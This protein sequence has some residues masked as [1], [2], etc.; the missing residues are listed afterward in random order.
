MT[1]AVIIDCLRTAVG[2]APRG[3][4][5]NTRP[6][7]MAAAVFKKLLEKHPQVNKAEID[8]VIL[9]CAMPEAES[10]MNFARIAAL[11]AGLPETVPGVTVNRFCSSGLQA[12]AMAAEKIRSGSAEIVLAGGAE[13]MSL[14]P[15][16]GNKFAPNP[17]MVDHI[18]EIYMGM[19]LTA[20]EVYRKYGISREEQDQFAYRSHRNALQA[21][22]KGKF[23]DEIVP[24]ELDTTALSNG[25]PSTEKSVF[26]KDEGP[27]ADTSPEALAKLK[28]VFHANGTVTAGNSSQTSDGAA[29][30][31]VMSEKKARELG[32]KPMARFVSF[33][34]G[35]VPPE[36][37]GIGPVVAIPKAL[38]LAGLKLGDIGVVELNEAFAVQSLAVIREAGL[39]MDTLNVNG[40]AI[41]LGHPLGC[42]GAKL[43]AT[44]L[45]EMARR[46]ARYGMVTMCIG[47]G[48]GAAGILER[49]N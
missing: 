11:R 1:E 2:K 40:G 4:L 17:W 24:L 38:K 39:N 5:K 44:I 8:D 18:P 14:V 12:I 43:T 27:R 37:M 26:K 21:Q 41:A 28:P 36:I 22:A 20:E 42:T 15:M 45:R 10:G 33:A 34:V 32:L 30:A 46:N 9:G 31:I 35:G 48:Q 19:G 7:D 3:T 49:L 25:K 16:G 47:G 6:D 23:D 29:A 13:S